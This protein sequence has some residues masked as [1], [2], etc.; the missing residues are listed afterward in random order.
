[1]INEIILDTVFFFFAE[2]DVDTGCIKSTDESATFTVEKSMTQSCTTLP[3]T[4]VTASN[5][6]VAGQ[7]LSRNEFTRKVAELE[8]YDKFRENIQEASKDEGIQPEKI[9]EAGDEITLPSHAELNEETCDCKIMLESYNATNSELSADDSVELDFNLNKLSNLTITNDIC[10]NDTVEETPATDNNANEDFPLNIIVEESNGP[11]VLEKSLCSKNVSLDS[12]T[13]VDQV[14]TLPI[15]ESECISDSNNFLSHTDSKVS[16]SDTIE[17]SAPNCQASV[18]DFETSISNTIP[19]ISDSVES[20][21]DSKASFSNDEHTFFDSVQ[22]VSKSKESVCDSE[23]SVSGSNKLGLDSIQSIFDSKLLISGTKASASELVSES[24]ML[25][26]ESKN[27]SSKSEA[28]VSGLKATVLGS[29]ALVSDSKISVSESK[30]SISVSKISVSDSTTSVSELKDSISQLENSVLESKKSVTESEPFVSYSKA[31][32][33]VSKK[34]P[35]DL[36]SL[37]AGSKMPLSGSKIFVSDSKALVSGS[38]SS[39]SVLEESSSDSKTSYTGT[40]SFVSGSKAPVSESKM[41]DS[42][43]KE[44]V[45]ESLSSVPLSKK[46]I[47]DSK[48]SD[49]VTI[50]SVSESKV[51]ASDSKI[52][53]SARKNKRVNKSRSDSSTNEISRS[54]DM[55]SKRSSPHSHDVSG[56]KYVLDETSCKKSDNSRTTEPSKIQTENV[57][58]SYG[59]NNSSNNVEISQKSDSVY[60]ERL[61]RNVSYSKNSK[62]DNAIDIDHDTKQSKF[63]S[64]V[65]SKTEIPSLD[66]LKDI[67]KNKKKYTIYMPSTIQCEE[68]IS[69]YLDQR[70]KNSPKFIDFPNGDHSHK[71]VMKQLFNPEDPSKPIMVPVEE[72]ETLKSVEPNI[73]LIPERSNHDGETYDKLMASIEKGSNEISYYIN[74]NRIPREFTCIM[75]IRRYLQRCYLKLF[76][77]NVKLC[78]ENKIQFDMWNILYH[79]LIEKLRSYIEE[80]PKLR[81]KSLS[82]LKLLVLD[83]HDFLQKLV[84]TLEKKYDV[85][86]KD[87]ASIETLDEHPKSVPR[88]SMIALV[89]IQNLLLNL[90]DLARYRQSVSS[91]EHMPLLPNRWYGLAA[92]LY[93]YNGRPWHQLAIL[94]FMSQKRPLDI[95]YYNARSLMATN[96]VM[97]AN[98]M[99][100]TFFDNVSRKIKS[101]KDDLE[102]L[103]DEVLLDEQDEK[104]TARQNRGELCREVWIRPTGGR[105]TSRRVTTTQTEDPVAILEQALTPDQVIYKVFRLPQSINDVVY[106]FGKS[107]HLICQIVEIS[108]DHG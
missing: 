81:D 66:V 82:T 40:K 39:I 93:P 78:Y 45:S 20:F 28:S 11:C 13:E 5:S 95:Y 103:P 88:I 90:G 19:T 83:G 105:A 106:I 73:L 46:S 8:P 4:F 47:S 100:M 49:I 16:T 60:N 107:K 22:T 6:D 58:N 41:S 70:K 21:T 31:S 7:L 102:A 85:S 25:V 51:T 10:I 86:L 52:T 92:R 96:A 36:K 57:R 79:S 3:V 18:A 35:S 101:V 84:A 65:I 42:N 64:N 72:E 59:R 98:D 50:S 33:S 76:S 61:S 26:S 69:H 68:N 15:L 99:L 74:T 43:L 108:R 14:S 87:A 67:T 62:E 27:Y 91:V 23:A 56:G 77:L 80:T 30:A 71:I 38:I 1:M 53:V 2:N 104:Q 29:E 54:N 24:K 94:S 34:S 32:V 75:D 63:A 37:D 17:D 89:V 12:E 97:S 44:S 48:T 55:Y 9:S